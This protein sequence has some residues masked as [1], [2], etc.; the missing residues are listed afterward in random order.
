MPHVLEIDK[1]IYTALVESFGEE[2]LKDKI[3]DILLSALESRLEQY[4][5]EILKFEEKYGMSFK[6]FSEKWDKGEI[7]DKYSYE[8][9]SDFIDWEMLEMEKKDLIS[10]LSRLKGIRKK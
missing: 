2:A 5:R 6:E 1:D 4:S 7:K 10:V 3:D 9:E 8:V